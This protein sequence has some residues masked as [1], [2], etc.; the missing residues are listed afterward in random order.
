MWIV[1]KVVRAAYGALN[2]TRVLDTPIGQAAYR[3]LY[4]QY[5]RRDDDLKIRSL[6][7]DIVPGTIAIDVGANIGTYATAFAKSVS[8][9]G[10]VLAIEA[11][12]YNAE[13]LRRRFVNSCNLVR[14]IE[15]A[16]SDRAGLLK[17]S[18]DE[19]NPAG[20]VLSSQGIDVRGVTLDD[21]VSDI[22]LPVSVIK[23]DVEGA[24]PLVI[25]GSKRTIERDRPTILLEYSPSRIA[26]FEPDPTSLLSYF[27]DLAYN[28]FLEGSA[29]PRSIQEVNLAAERRQYVD[30]LLRP[31]KR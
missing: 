12:P 13:I 25:R 29:V 22:N 10:I 31:T 30:V 23:I 18:R 19:K 28:C 5:K 14:V 2:T 15:A 26:P 4:E 27:R 20:H 11:D 24:E 16:A 1:H 17:L 9:G 8:N 7:D 6:C 21:I 3:Y